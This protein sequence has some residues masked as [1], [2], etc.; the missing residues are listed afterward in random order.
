MEEENEVKYGTCKFCGK[1]VF[2]LYGE[3][4]EIAN[5]RATINCGCAKSRDYKFQ[6]DQEKE[7]E[8]NIQ[9]IKTKLKEFAVHCQ[10]RNIE[11]K[12][13][14]QSLVL[15]FAIAVLDGECKS[16]TFKH[17]SNRMKLT[18]KGTAKGGVLI[19]LNYDDSQSI[20]V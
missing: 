20:E 10:E 11:F 6:K 15:K 3:T 9:T 8:K 16:L 7:R 14:M 4:Q 19:K 18:V 1:T 2:A 5:E 17:N 13:E 12:E